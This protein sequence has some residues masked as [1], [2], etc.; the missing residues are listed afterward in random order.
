LSELFLIM[1]EIFLFLTLTFVVIGEIAYHGEQN[2]LIILTSLVGLGG[3][4][5]QTLIAYRYG[6]TEIF[7]HT[8]TVDGL[9]LFFKLLFIGLAA[10]AVI[11]VAHTNE[12]P[13]ERKTE[14]CALILAGSLSMCLVASAADLILIFLSLLFLNMISYFLAGYGKTSVKSTEA[15][16]KY[17]VFS[18][19]AGT[20]LLYGMAILFGVSHSLNIYAIHHALTAN[21]LTH[22]TIL[23]IFMLVFAA[24]SFQ[25]GVFPMHLWTPDVLE[26]APTPASAFLS[27]GC[28]AAGFAVAIR[29]LIAIFTQNSSSQ[30][31]WQ[32]MG[33]V[34]WTQILALVSGLTMAFG[35]LLAFRQKSAKRMVGCLVMAE[36]GYLLL[37][38]VVL[39]QVGIAAILYNL[40]I[41][42]FA[43]V[44]IFYVLSFIFDELGSD[45]LVDLRGMLGRAVP[46]C[47]CLVLFLLCLVGMPPTPGFIGKFTLIGVALRHRW[48][49]L[50]LIAIF[51]IAVSTVAVSKL[52]YSLLGEFKAAQPRALSFS[53]TQVS[54]VWSRKI[55]L[56]SLVIPLLLIGVFAETVLD[57]AGR[58]LG[59]I[60]W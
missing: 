27:V 1:P 53:E 13:I 38:L 7:A 51:S 42:L 12:V 29:I 46:E 22:P 33:S 6:A 35:S 15:A 19:V 49:V 30:G 40:V 54:G 37:G 57:L 20:L 18:T 4:L 2:R 17:M 28:R 21:T 8:Y 43:L 39:D 11:T 5:V 44:G 24:I 3:A 56:M 26:G 16:V 48:P 10:L 45:L 58:S 52:A 50:G 47:I 34:D 60:F 36:S 14:Y 25:L 41:E 32:V 31:Q 59:F 55:F 9:S 23:I